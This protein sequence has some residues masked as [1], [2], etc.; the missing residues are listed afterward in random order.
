LHPYRIKS[1]LEYPDFLPSKETACFYV[2][3]DNEDLIASVKTTQKTLKEFDDLSD[4]QLQKGLLSY[5]VYEI[6]MSI[7]NRIRIILKP[8][9]SRKTIYEIKYQDVD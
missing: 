1:R 4:K 9:I 2:W 3:T 8:K 5:A 6:G 7:K